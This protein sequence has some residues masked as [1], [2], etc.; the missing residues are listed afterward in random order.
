MLIEYHNHHQSINGD[1]VEDGI[2]MAPS[3]TS[4]D[5]IKPMT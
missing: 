5:H 3:E 1:D 2:E 4:D